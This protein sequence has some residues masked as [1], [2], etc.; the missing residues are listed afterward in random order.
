MLQYV[1]ELVMGH[2]TDYIYYIM[3]GKKKK[4]EK[5]I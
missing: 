2:I 4:K 5:M 1:H 3:P